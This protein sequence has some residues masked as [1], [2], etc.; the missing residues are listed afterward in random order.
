LVLVGFALAL[1][2]GPLTVGLLGAIPAFGQLAQLPAIVLVERLRR[3][4]LLAVWFGNSER[5]LVLLLA[6]FAFFPDRG[7]ALMLL[8]LGEL[9]IA[10][11]AAMSACVWNSWM[12]DLLPRHG[13]NAFFARR[14]SWSTIV[15]LAGGLAAGVLVDNYWPGRKPRQAYAAASVSAS[16]SGFVS[17]WFLSLVP[18]PAMAPVSDAAPRLTT[19]WT[20]FGKVEGS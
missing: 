8:I 4:G 6:A 7:I 9:L 5:M 16:L 3:R 18:E 11:T 12:H 2:A 14:L 15:S 1:G 20:C 13:T 19:M 17:S 10:S